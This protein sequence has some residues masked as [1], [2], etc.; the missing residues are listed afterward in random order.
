[1]SLRIGIV[2]FGR[3]GRA[4][5]R[6]GFDRPGIEFVA[7]C[8]DGD[9]EALLYLLNHSTVEGAFDSPA[10]L[11]G[12]HFVDGGQRARVLKQSTPGAVPWDSLGVDYVFDCTGEYRTKEALVKHCQAG[13]RLVISSTPPS[14]A[15]FPVIVRGVNCAGVTGDERIISCGSSSIHALSL[16]LK[17]LLDGPGV[18]AAS[19]TSVHAYTGNQHLADSASVSLRWSRSAAQNIIPNETWAPEVAASL[20]PALDGKI[21]GVA[22]NVPV[23]A[24]SNID[25]VAKLGK[26]LSAGE[27]NDLFLRAAEGPMRGLLGYTDAPIVSSDVIGDR[28]SALFDSN[29]TLA[30]GSGLVKTLTWFDNGW[31]FAERMLETAELHAKRGGAA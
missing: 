8:D 29:A 13:A 21:D 12:N 10:I 25:L 5:F 9:A 26:V 7:I 6:L 2:G 20:L 16:V 1:M 18:D 23:A 3:I 22:L 30:M 14:D 27:V 4:L 15:S 11:E 24:G 17:V 31:A 28:H 19:M